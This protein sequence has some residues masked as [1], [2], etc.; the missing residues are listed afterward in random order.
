MEAGVLC[1]G[2]TGSVLP[3]SLRF[4]RLPPLAD[5]VPPRLSEAAIFTWKGHRDVLKQPYASLQPRRNLR[6]PPN[7]I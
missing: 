4:I 1:L 3:E 2:L 6:N 5:A 7:L